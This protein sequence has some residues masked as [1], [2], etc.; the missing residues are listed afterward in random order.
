MR[1]PL[2]LNFFGYSFE[3]LKENEILYVKLVYLLWCLVILSIVYLLLWLCSH[4]LVNLETPLLQIFCLCS[5]ILELSS[6]TTRFSGLATY[7]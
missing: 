4:T 7:P 5:L 6:C 1:I 3:I 2:C